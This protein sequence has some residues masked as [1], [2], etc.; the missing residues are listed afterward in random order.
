MSQL[1]FFFEDLD[2]LTSDQRQKT[3]IFIQKIFQ[4]IIKNPN[5]DKFRRLNKGKISKKFNKN[6]SLKIGLSL[7]KYVGFNEYTDQNDGIIRL[8]F[9]KNKLNELIRVHTMIIKHATTN[10]PS[11]RQQYNQDMIDQLIKLNV[12]NRNEII[13]AIDNVIN[14]NDINEVREYVDKYQKATLGLLEMG[15]DDKQIEKA[16]IATN[17]D[18]HQAAAIILAQNE[19]GYNHDN[20]DDEEEKQINYNC[21]I[22]D[23]KSIVR[24]TECLQVYQGLLLEDVNKTFNQQ[25]TPQLTNDFNHIL[26]VHL[27]D[28]KS[29]IEIQKEFE[30]I[31]EYITNRMNSFTVCNLESCNK[32][33][34]NSRDRETNKPDK[35][36]WDK[37]S[38]YFIDLMDTI[39]CYF[40]HSF[41]LFRIKSTDIKIEQKQDNVNDNSKDIQNGVKNHK[42]EYILVEDITKTWE[43]RRALLK[44]LRSTENNKFVTDIGKN[45][46]KDNE[47]QQTKT[48][49]D[50]STTMK[51]KVLSNKDEM[52]T[53][54]SFGFRYNYWQQWNPTYV[55]CKWSNLKSEILNNN[56]RRLNIKAFKSAQYKTSQKFNTHY[57]KKTKICDTRDHYINRY[58]LFKDT[59][60]TEEHLLT[61]ILYT[62][63]SKLCFKFSQTFRAID[64]SDTMEICK[65]R[66]SEYANWSK[67]LAETINLYGDRARKN[68]IYYH[69]INKLMIFSEFASYY[70]SPTSTTVQQGMYYNYIGHTLSHQFINYVGVAITFAS[71]NGAL[72]ELVRST[73]VAPMYYNCSW[74]SAYSN[75]DERYITYTHYTRITYQL[76]YKLYTDYL[77]YLI[78]IVHQEHNY[79]YWQLHQ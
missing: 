47:D 56:I 66:N 38:E 65:K 59:P 43:S 68:V 71:N 46:N 49:T 29:K 58:G 40:I 73:D 42:D 9:D 18:F 64:K 55:P 2:N 13:L 27:S 20:D 44:N 15:F 50:K 1:D 12:G 21:P 51:E 63:Y 57:R 62:D 69:G 79:E 39:H 61:V 75:E 31:C 33:Q 45:D 30:A 17:N 48:Q 41:D 26:N 28:E 72:L 35:Y 23:C 70:S 8:L 67:L 60:I 37:E 36:N 3:L 4:N 19:S 32:F 34:R 11:Q 6:N 25:K 5:E 14:K 77:Q 78:I 53:D 74:M 54:Y 24:I 7:L 76:W 16:L 10:I 52:A 22:D